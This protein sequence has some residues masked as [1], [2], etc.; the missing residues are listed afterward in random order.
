MNQIHKDCFAYQN[1]SA[2]GC[3]ILK[4]L[5]CLKENCKF[6]KTDRDGKYQHQLSDR[7]KI[8]NLRRGLNV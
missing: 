4:E 2:N 7:E 5:Y 8:N 6:Y 1:S 3:A